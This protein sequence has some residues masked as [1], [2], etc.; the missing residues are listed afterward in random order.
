MKSSSQTRAA[1]LAIKK[2]AGMTLMEIIA[3][4]AIIAAVIVGALALF[5]SAQSSNLSVSMLKALT[6][7]RSATQ[8]LYQGQGTYGA[9][10]A[11]LNNALINGQ[12]V[13]NDLVT[14]ATVT[15]ATI[16]P[17]W[18]GGSIVVAATANPSQFGITFTNVPQDVC[19]QLVSNSSTG[20]FSVARAAAADV[21]TATKFPVSPQDAAGTYC[22]S[23]GP[24][25][26]ISWA[27]QN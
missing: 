3:A 11:N 10:G 22:T 2:Q 9:A 17:P 24:N 7:L 13:P 21:A 26:T 27:S 19:I 15:P 4:L 8:Q 12:K 25:N 6:S 5:N 16:T 23:A 1:V 20:W 14:D 18:P